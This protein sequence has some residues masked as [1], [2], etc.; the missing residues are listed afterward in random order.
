[1]FSCHKDLGTQPFSLAKKDIYATELPY[2]W[3]RV[4]KMAMKIFNRFTE[5]ILLYISL[6]TVYQ[7]HILPSKYIRPKHQIPLDLINFHNFFIHLIDDECDCD[8]LPASASRTHSLSNPIRTSGMPIHATLLPGFS[9]NDS[10]KNSFPWLP[11][12]GAGN[13]SCSTISPSRVE[14]FYYTVNVNGHISYNVKKQQL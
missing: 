2:I 1:M 8:E 3:H 13:T 10:N 5:N 11:R 12:D 7:Q 14:H 6:I 9:F 4:L